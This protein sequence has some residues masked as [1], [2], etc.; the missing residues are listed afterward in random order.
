MSCIVL[1]LASCRVVSCR[2]VSCRVV[3]CR[4]LSGLA[5]SC[6]IG[7]IF[8]V[9]CLFLSSLVLSCQVLFYLSCVGY[10][11]RVPTFL[12]SRFAAHALVDCL[13]DRQRPVNPLP[14]TSF[15]NDATD[16]V[17]TGRCR[18]GKRS[19]SATTDCGCSTHILVRVHSFEESEP[20]L[21]T[22][23][24]NAQAQACA[25]CTNNS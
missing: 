22:L 18:S 16:G 3:S 8:L 25:Y 15:Q 21:R 14:A 7:L 19:P 13:L 10:Q 4:I 24:R 11:R 17:V 20:W 23:P 6:L 12:A 1:F 9:L 2:V 5:W